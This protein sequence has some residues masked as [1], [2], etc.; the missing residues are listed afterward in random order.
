VKFADGSKVFTMKVRVIKIDQDDI[1]W[2]PIAASTSATSSGY[3]VQALDVDIATGDGG[4]KIQR[5]A[6]L[7]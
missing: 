2:V 5:S 6:K 1:F 7:C 4:G 3:Y